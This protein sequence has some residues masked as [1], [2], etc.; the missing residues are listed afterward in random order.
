[1]QNATYNDSVTTNNG[2]SGFLDSTSG[3][4]NITFSSLSESNYFV[5]FYAQCIGTSGSGSSG[6][7]ITLQLQGITTDPNSLATIGLDTRSV[8]KGTTAFLAFGSASYR[9]V[10][11]STTSNTKTINKNNTYRLNVDVGKAYDLTD[12]KLTIRV[13]PM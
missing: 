7:Y 12:I 3:T 8:S 4:A 11:T 13:T 1:M 9:I 5:E 10:S 6:N 2:F